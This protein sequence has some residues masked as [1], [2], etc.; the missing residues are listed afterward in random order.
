M[1]TVYYDKN[2]FFAAPV[3][4]ERMPRR[5]AKAPRENHH[6]PSAPFIHSFVAP[7]IIVTENFPHAIFPGHHDDGVKH[8]LC[9]QSASVSIE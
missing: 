4:V 3:P 7:I 8:P 9:R 6:P 1:E 2:L 5:T